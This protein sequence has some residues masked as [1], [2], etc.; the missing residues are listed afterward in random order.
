[1]K[2]K[3]ILIIGLILVF[4][5]VI[6]LVKYAIGRS[7]K[8]GEIKVESQP[9]ASI[10]LNDKHFG[11]TPIGKTTQKVEAGEYVMKIVPDNSISPLASWQGKITINPN[12]ITYVNAILGESELTSTIDVLWLEKISGKRSEVSVLTTPDSATVSL[13]DETKGTT[14]TVITDVAPGD[15]TIT[16]IS[17]GFVTRTVK[18]RATQGYKIVASIKLGLSATGL[19]VREASP[20]AV[21]KEDKAASTS[22]KTTKATPTPTPT[23]KS[24]AEVRGAVVDGVEKPYVVIKENELGYL[25]VRTEPINGSESARLKAGE[26]YHIYDT[27]SGWFQI[28]TLD[29]IVGWIVGS[30]QYVEKVE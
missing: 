23:P 21:V 12:T 29:G 7:P 27:K 28:H 20:S 1:M 19:I 8:Q 6:I 17:Q 18:I 13:D 5:V 9:Q 24:T 16:V 2:Q 22:A 30:A 10:F 11:R 3:F 26:K 15:H 25:R 14:P 4:G